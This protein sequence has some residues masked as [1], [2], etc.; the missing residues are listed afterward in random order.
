M[1][2]MTQKPT[3][4]TRSGHILTIAPGTENPLPVNDWFKKLEAW[5]IRNT[6][7]V[8]RISVEEFLE[9][10]YADEDAGELL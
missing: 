10:K 7:H 5:R 2:T 1:T 6:K 8:T 4:T 3:M 9:E